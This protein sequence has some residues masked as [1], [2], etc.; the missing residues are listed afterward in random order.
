MWFVVNVPKGIECKD[1]HA[2]VREAYNNVLGVIAEH[3]AKV[4]ELQK[5]K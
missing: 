1:K 5:K 3:N 2:A 4:E